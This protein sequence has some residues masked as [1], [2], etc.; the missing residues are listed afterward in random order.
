VNVVRDR[1]SL[2]R[3]VEDGW[4]ENVY[5]LQL[6]NA[7][8]SP[9]RYRLEADGLPGLKLS[10]ATTV[11]LAPTEARWV[12]VALR[13]PPEAAQQLKPGAHPVQWRISRDG[14]AGEAVVEKSTFVLPR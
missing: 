7:T 8:E 4:I 14:G 6:M 12:A 1:A 13:V 11:E 5:R 9:Q 10:Q 2:A 3:L